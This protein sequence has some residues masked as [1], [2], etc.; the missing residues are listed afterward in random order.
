MEHKHLII[1]AT[2]KKPFVNVNEAEA[3]MTALVKDIGMNITEHG[4]P[5]V[6]YV[7]K[8]G[9]HGIAAM[10]MIETSHVSLHVWDKQDPPLVQMDV[11]SCS[12]FNEDAVIAFLSEMEPDHIEYL[13]IDRGKSLEMVDETVHHLLSEESEFAMP[14]IDPLGL[15]R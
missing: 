1:R 13:L 7:K 12:D 14:H 3:W 9:N 5:H 6:D 10:A 11:Y 2:V 15:R 4:G 8:E